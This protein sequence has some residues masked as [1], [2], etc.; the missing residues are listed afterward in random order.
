[1]PTNLFVAYLLLCCIYALVVVPIFLLAPHV[2]FLSAAVGLGLLVLMLSSHTCMTTGGCIVVPWIFV[3]LYLLVMLVLLFGAAVI[4]T[5]R[6]K[7][8]TRLRHSGLFGVDRSTSSGTTE[9]PDDE[10]EETMDPEDAGDDGDSTDQENGRTRG[11]RTLF[12]DR[13]KELQRR[14]MREK[15]RRGLI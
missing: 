5:S 14:L 11:F 3:I 12:R 8:G 6:F 2:G 13:Q 7:W 4:L 10:A 1:M 9:D 15:E